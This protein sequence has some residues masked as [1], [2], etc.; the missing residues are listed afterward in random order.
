[1]EIQLVG[2]KNYVWHAVGHHLIMKPN[3]KLAYHMNVNLQLLAL[4][5]SIVKRVSK[6]SI[7]IKGFCNRTIFFNY[8]LLT[9]RG[10]SKKIAKRLAAHQMW[11]RLQDIPLDGTPLCDEDGNFEVSKFNPINY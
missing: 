5:L 2:Y 3:W 8:I 7:N 11:Q 6:L 10:K 4:L 1:M 9:G